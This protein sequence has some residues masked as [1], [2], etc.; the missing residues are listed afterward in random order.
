MKNGY[1]NGPWERMMTHRSDFPLTLARWS[2]ASE[3]CQQTSDFLSYWPR[4]PSGISTI[5][6]IF[7]KRKTKLFSWKNLQIS[8]NLK[9]KIMWPS[10]EPNH[11]PYSKGP[12]RKRSKNKHKRLKTKQQTFQKYFAS[13]FAPC[14][15][16]LRSNHA[17]DL[18]NCCDCVN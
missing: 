9:K 13:A 11:R 3:H 16:V 2:M 18:L 8:K 6:K 14:E 1:I 5:A 7:K 12:I 10:I 17:C 15:W 4:L